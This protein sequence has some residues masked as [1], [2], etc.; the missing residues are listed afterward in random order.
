MGSDF[1]N[2]DTVQHKEYS[3]KGSALNVY[4]WG[5]TRVTVEA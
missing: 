1:P 4:K 3:T 2:V 5:V